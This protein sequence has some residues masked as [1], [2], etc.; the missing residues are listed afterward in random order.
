MQVEI[1]VV[2]YWQ[3]MGKNSAEKGVKSNTLQ[4]VNFK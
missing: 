4:E 1:G 2:W 3:V